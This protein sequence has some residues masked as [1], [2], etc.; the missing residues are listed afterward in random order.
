MAA[1]RH[2][3]F[4]TLQWIPSAAAGSISPQAGC[5]SSKRPSPLLPS[6]PRTGRE[7]TSCQQWSLP[8]LKST[9]ISHNQLSCIPI[10][11]LL[12]PTLFFFFFLCQTSRNTSVCL[13]LVWHNLPKTESCPQNQP[14]ATEPR[15]GM[16]MCVCY[17]PGGHSNRL[18]NPIRQPSGVFGSTHTH[19]HTLIH[20][21]GHTHSWESLPCVQLCW[22]HC[23]PI[24]SWEKSEKCFTGR[25]K[26]T[27]IR[28]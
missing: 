25:R 5:P 28:L 3:C 16:C 23:L 9:I 1:E 26:Q 7:W 6:P 21:Y 22:S 14:A 24:L 4:L 12:T 2:F 27:L 8:L 19:T 17:M 13:L 15:P 20:A 11:Y 18:F 10:H